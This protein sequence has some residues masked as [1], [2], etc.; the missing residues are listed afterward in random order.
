MIKV[1]YI[2][3]IYYIKY[4]VYNVSILDVPYY[5]VRLYNLM[6]FFA[7]AVPAVRLGDEW[8]IIENI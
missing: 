2:L 7:P 1:L 8:E 5:A 6:R 4:K 3:L